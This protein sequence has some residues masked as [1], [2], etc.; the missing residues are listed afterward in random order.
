M[1]ETEGY[2]SDGVASPL[3]QSNDGS[4]DASCFLSFYDGQIWNFKE[5]GISSSASSSRGS[6]ASK[7][8]RRG[9]YVV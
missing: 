8:F 2:S 7:I 6:I 4:E 9:F 1:D 3:R 5:A